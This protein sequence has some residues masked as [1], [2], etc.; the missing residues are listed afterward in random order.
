MKELVIEV[1]ELYD[2]QGMTIMEIVKKTGLSEDEVITVLSDYS[3]TFAQAKSSGGTV[4]KGLLQQ[5]YYC[6]TIHLLF[7]FY[8]ESCFL[9]FGRHK[10]FFGQEMVTRSWLQY[11]RYTIN[12][13]CGLYDTLLEMGNGVFRR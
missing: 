7:I 6:S 13:Q 10:N 1:C 12:S 8:G 9:G 5:V 2:E 11:G 3:D 4:G